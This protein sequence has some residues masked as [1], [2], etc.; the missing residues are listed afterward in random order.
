MDASIPVSTS[1]PESN[2]SQSWTVT[3]CKFAEFSMTKS[4]PIEY[5]FHRHVGLGMSLLS[6]RE[7]VGGP[8][9]EAIHVGPMM[10]MPCEQRAV[11]GSKD[12]SCDSSDIM[13][14]A[15]SFG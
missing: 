5:R 11:L 8:V 14:C 10:W 6:K 12:H 4:S 3:I 15:F 7:N 9:K 13:L 2:F 1:L